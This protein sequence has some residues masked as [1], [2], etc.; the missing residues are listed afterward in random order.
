MDWSMVNL[1]EMTP[2]KPNQN[3]TSPPRSSQQMSKSAGIRNLWILFLIKQ[4]N[5]LLR[6]CRLKC[7]QV[8]SLVHSLMHAKKTWRTLIIG[9][10]MKRM[11]KS[12]V[13]S[14]SFSIDTNIFHGKCEE[15]EVATKKW[16]C[17]WW[18]VRRGKS[19]SWDGELENRQGGWKGDCFQSQTHIWWGC[20]VCK[21][22]YEKPAVSTFPLTVL[23]KND[24]FPDLKATL[25][26][27]LC[28]CNNCLYCVS[29][30]LII[31]TLLD[32]VTI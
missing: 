32:A 1:P 21:V 13:R 25:G 8:F 7:F 11:W 9:E 5:D 19:R 16:P 10:Q 22:D 26:I 4:E 20:H 30:P 17:Q 28:M 29:Q 6:R 27:H 2:Q 12:I 23:P 18:W 3:Q 24:H 31:W 15:N 14:F